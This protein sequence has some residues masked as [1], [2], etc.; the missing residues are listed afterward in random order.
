MGKQ[1]HKEAAEMELAFTVDQLARYK[2]HVANSVNDALTTL[3]PPDYAIWVTSEGLGELVD[4]VADM[5][6]QE[7]VETTA[8][9]LATSNPA[10]L[11]NLILHYVRRRA[12]RDYR[13]RVS[14]RIDVMAEEA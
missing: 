10:L 14:N 13:L 3:T 11:G 1:V 5:P 4:I 7:F 9:A 6:Q 12:A 2:P 8:Q